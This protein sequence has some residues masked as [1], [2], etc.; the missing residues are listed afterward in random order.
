MNE[1]TWF[2]SN[3]RGNVVFNFTPVPQ[4]DELGA[5]A[6]GYQNAAETLLQSVMSKAGYRDCDCYPIFYLYRHALELYIK[7]V[8]YRGAKLLELVTDESLEIDLVTT[9]H[10][11]ERFLPG[12]E[13]IFKDRGWLDGVQGQEYQYMVKVIANVETIDPKSISFRYPT[14]RRNVS[15]F[16]KHTVINVIEFARDVGH[17][18]DLLGGALMALNEDWQN[19]AEVCYAIQ[20]ILSQ[21]G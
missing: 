7:A 1:N 15:P 6:A 19:A 3:K 11:L 14:T 9:D 13:A 4:I 17:V 2:S 5:F 8:F 12:I 21:E 20:E 10:R 18:L 16:G